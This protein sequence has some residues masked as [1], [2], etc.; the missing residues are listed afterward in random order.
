MSLTTK[1]F[2]LLVL[3]VS[4][5][6]KLVSKEEILARIW[7][8]VNVDESNLS[9]TVS[10]LRKALSGTE[11]EQYI[12]N[13]PKKGYRFAADIQA[14]PVSQQSPHQVSGRRPSHLKTA[15]VVLSLSAVFGLALLYRFH[16]VSSTDR[17]YRK[18][19]ELERQG[20]DRLALEALKEVLRAKPDFADARVR[21]AWIEYQDDQ[22]DAASKYLDRSGQASSP[23]GTGS[24]DPHSRCTRLKAEGLQ[25]LLSNN[26]EDALRKLDLALQADPGDAD[27][28]YYE[29]DLA[30]DME[31]YDKADG[32][33]ARC[34]QTDPSHP[35]C[36]Y[37][38][39][40]LRI[41]QGRFDDVYRV[42][43]RVPQGVRDYPWFD[44]PTGFAELAK[45]NT[46]KALA[47]FRTL[48]ESG[49]RLG[50]S[51][52]FRASQD[53]ITEVALYEGRIEDARRQLIAALQSSTS[54]HERADYLVYLAQIDALTGRAVSAKE[55]L[56]NATRLS[57]DLDL[58]I[59]A[60]NVLAQIGDFDDAHRLLNEYRGSSATSGS[61]FSGAENFLAGAEL[62][63][64]SDYVQ[65]I[66]RIEDAYRFA[67]QPAFAYYLAQV[68]IHAH[69]WED[70]IKTL[71]RLLGSK[72]TFLMGESPA[73]LIPLAERDLAT[74]EKHLGNTA[75]A[76]RHTALAES[77]WS[78]ADHELRKSITASGDH[79]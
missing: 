42:R 48:A 63:S 15:T 34:L 46:D 2:D 36:F 58:T 74:C 71:N 32:L 24:E 79:Q 9:T 39:M 21:A 44:E 43:E 78:Q 76:A 73:L 69:K 10:M 5:E 55:H 45:G 50:S 67:P 52:H 33:L 59:T 6:G 57:T 4:N 19:I 25:M 22:D 8:D 60:S 37:D 28:A 17:F 35:S 70:A 38:L 1:A 75:E 11:T 3:L 77:A 41:R 40:V 14:V 18:A 49:H 68:Q 66:A 61:I 56:Q 29:A 53:G 31:L 47:H 12:E 26:R 20:N 72:G 30:T 7:P 23:P 16:Q 13:V 51:V 64:K 27:A 62:R 54:T 65:A